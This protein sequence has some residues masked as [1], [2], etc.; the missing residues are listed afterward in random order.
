MAPDSPVDVELADRQLAGRAAA[1][2]CARSAAAWRKR[3]R[4]PGRRP[5][6]RVT[7]RNAGPR[8]PVVVRPGVDHGTVELERQLGGRVAWGAQIPPAHQHHDRPRLAPDHRLDGPAIEA[9]SLGPHAARRPPASATT[10]PPP[11]NPA[12][13]AGTTRRRS[14]A[15]RRIR[16]RSGHV[17][18]DSPRPSAGC[19]GRTG[20][21]RCAGGRP[22]TTRSRVSPRRKYSSSP[23]HSLFRTGATTGRRRGAAA[24]SER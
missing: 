2:G 21:G 9:G 15:P 22:G 18:A 11:S 7:C 4:P 8:R 16:G 17:P 13:T 20:P 5:A 6:S 3:P 19:G 1:R 23:I 12:A 10:P 14:A 24:C